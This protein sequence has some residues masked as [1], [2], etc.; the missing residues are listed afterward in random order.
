MLYGLQRG[1]TNTTP[2]D[3]FLQLGGGEWLV[4]HE[5]NV[6]KHLK[7]FQNLAQASQMEKCI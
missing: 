4:F 3:M 5:F 7:N 2:L 6:I 1:T